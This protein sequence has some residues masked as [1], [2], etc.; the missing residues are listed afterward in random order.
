MVLA[1]K[2]MLS[3]LMQQGGLTRHFSSPA[4]PRVLLFR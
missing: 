2:V 4:C 3:Q 1:V